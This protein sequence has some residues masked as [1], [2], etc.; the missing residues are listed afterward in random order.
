MRRDAVSHVMVPPAVSKPIDKGV[1]TKNSKSCTCEDPSSVR[2]RY[3]RAPVPRYKGWSTISLATRLNQ[4][5]SFTIVFFALLLLFLLLLRGA[6]CCCCL[7]CCCYVAMAVALCGRCSTRCNVLSV[8][9]LS[10]CLLSH[11]SHFASSARH[12]IS[13]TMSPSRAHSAALLA[14]RQTRRRPL[15]LRMLDPSSIRIH[16][17][18]LHHVM[19][20]FDTH[21][22]HKIDSVLSFTLLLNAFFFRSI[23]YLFTF[24]FSPPWASTSLSCSLR[25]F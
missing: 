13:S 21:C 9:C 1:M 10:V 8:H 24:L 6:C 23:S 18:F 16:H 2:L 7:G 14:A 4:V 17:A 25:S 22:F 15:A 11:F 12:R 3:N 19:C 5:R 20:L